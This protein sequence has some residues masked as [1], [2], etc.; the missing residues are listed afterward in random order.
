M[1]R[2]GTRIQRI[3]ADQDRRAKEKSA[4]PRA[5]SLPRFLV[6]IRA[7]PLNPRSSACY[8][9]SAPVI[10]LTFAK[11]AFLRSVLIDQLTGGLW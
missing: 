4:A 11:N 8:L 7:N 6:F 2:G 10:S 5:P 9:S 1:G 3:P